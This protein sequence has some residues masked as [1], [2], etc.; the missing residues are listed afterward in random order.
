MQ[1]SAASASGLS[2]GRS[3]GWASDAEKFAPSSPVRSRINQKHVGTSLP[4]AHPHQ[5]DAR[6]HLPSRLPGPP[7]APARHSDSN[8]NFNPNLNQK[9]R[10][11]GKNGVAL[12]APT[13]FRNENGQRAGVAPALPSAPSVLERPNYAR[14]SADRT[15]EKNPRVFRGQWLDAAVVKCGRRGDIVLG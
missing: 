2:Q 7:S 15:N 5:P 13:G 1:T 12:R 9:G 11:P 4:T 10:A 6:C 3:G 14:P 8:L